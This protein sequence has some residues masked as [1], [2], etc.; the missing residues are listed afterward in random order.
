LSPCDWGKERRRA[1]EEKCELYILLKFKPNG[2]L[3]LGMV[4]LILN[5]QRDKKK[6]RL[7]I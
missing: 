4:R 6:S 7:V 1:K 2:Q 3:I 5:I